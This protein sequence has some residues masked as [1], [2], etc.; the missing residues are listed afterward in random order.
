MT[1][2]G[3]VINLALISHTGEV[4]IPP[5]TQQDVNQGVISPKIGPF[6]DSPVASSIQ[7]NPQ[8]AES[9]LKSN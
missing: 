9:K 4:P 6:P 7:N 5:I 3:E 8:L 2:R 1:F